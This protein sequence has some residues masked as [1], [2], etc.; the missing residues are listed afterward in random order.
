MPLVHEDDRETM[1]KEMEKL[2]R[3]PHTC[4]VEQRFLTKDGWRWLAWAVKAV[5]DEERRVIA[6]VGVGRDIT[7]RKQA[8]EQ[9]QRSEHQMRIKNQIANL[10]LTRPDE[11][12][13]GEVLQVLLKV[14]DSD[15]GLFGYIA[16]DGILA[17]SSLTDDI[18][19]RCEVAG[20]NIFFPY[21]AW[22]GFG[23]ERLRIK[24]L[25]IPTIHTRCLR[26]MCPYPD[27]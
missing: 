8:E 23:V 6:I 1:I 9:L 18:W 11:E 20:K 14:F 10:F 5:F 13:Y 4:H 17:L 27:H 19:D 7:K 26:G 24:R 21:E 22:G 15:Y 2:Y 16:E 12:I 3:P 25:I